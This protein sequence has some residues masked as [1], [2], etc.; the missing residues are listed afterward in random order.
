MSSISFLAAASYLAYLAFL[1]SAIYWFFYA[2]SLSLCFL[3]CSYIRSIA[4]L[5]SISFTC[6]S[7]C[8]SFLSIS[9]IFALCARRSSSFRCASY[10]SRTNLLTSAFRFSSSYLCLATCSLCSLIFLACS[11]YWACLSNIL[12]RSASS[13]LFFSSANLFCSA[14]LWFLAYNY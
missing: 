14:S 7:L 8:L 3:S 13:F 12:Y 5:C 1:A 9:A 2:I 11:I 10:S 6:T 4:A